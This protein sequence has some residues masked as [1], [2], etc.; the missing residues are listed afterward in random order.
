MDKVTLTINGI[1]VT[2]DKNS[3]VLTAAREAGIYIPTLCYHPDL[4]EKV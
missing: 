4:H 3:S 1:S 2:T